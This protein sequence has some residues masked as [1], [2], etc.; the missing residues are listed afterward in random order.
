GF[1]VSGTFRDP[2]DFAVAVLYD[3][4]NFFEHPRIKYLPDFDL[5]GLTLRFDVRYSDGVQPIDSP[6]FN[7]I[8]W[9][10][11]DC[12]REDGTTAQVRLWDN[13]MLADSSFPAASV[14]CTLLTGG[15]VQPFDRATLWYQNLA[16]DYIVPVGNT[17]AEFAF[18][19]GGTGTVHSVTVNGTVY[20]HTESN[21]LGESSSDQA[22]ALAAALAGDPYVTASSSANSVQL[23]VRPAHD[24]IA[25]PVSASDGNAAVTMKYVSPDF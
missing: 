22:D 16:F 10:T 12:I 18:F 20:S 19:A 5:A 11:L 23:T 15:S 8:D 6:K 3:T 14:T 25:F 7:W 4:D 13:A 21:P 24:G 1:T 9:A 17:S 2:A